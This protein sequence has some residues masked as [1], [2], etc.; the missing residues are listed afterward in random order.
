MTTDHQH[1][2]YAISSYDHTWADQFRA[3]AAAVQSIFG[4]LAHTIEH[5]GST[6]VPG[7]AAKPTI[8]ILVTTDHLNRADQLTARLEG[9]GYEA[10]GANIDPTSRLFVKDDGATRL[11]NLHIFPADDPHVVELRAVRDYLASNKAA[12]E[13]YG[14][15]KLRLVHEYPTDYASYR[16]AKDEYMKSVLL[17]AA[18]RTYQRGKEHL[19]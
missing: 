8:D 9:I 19:T 7:L 3:E 13:E 15:L 10:L 18:I 16:H 12:A 11:V 2:R 5:V 14:G 4:S 1:R 6:A 17:P